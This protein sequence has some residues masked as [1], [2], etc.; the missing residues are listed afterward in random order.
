MGLV[1][2][3][4]GCDDDLGP[5]HCSCGSPV[6]WGASPETAYSIKSSLQP[7]YTLLW[8]KYFVDGC[9]T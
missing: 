4:G 9:T 5:R 8:N 2:P 1:G 6:S 3:D 7:I